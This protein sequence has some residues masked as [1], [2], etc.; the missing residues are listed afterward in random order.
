MT[1]YWRCLSLSL[2]TGYTQVLGWPLLVAALV[3]AS[4]GT[5]NGTYSDQASRDR[6]A[7]AYELLSGSAALQGRGYDLHTLGGIL[8]NEMGYLTLI[9]IPLIGVHLAIRFTRSV[10]DTGRL[11]ILTS[12]PV[13]RLAPAAAGV[14]A[15]AVTA[16]I[17]AVITAVG[18][19]ALDY[20]LGGSWLYAGGL[21]MFMLV[22]TGVGTLIAQCCRTARTAYL[23]AAGAWLIS[24]LARAAVD[25]QQWAAT[26]WNP[27]SWL[28]EIKP[29]AANPPWWP[30]I[31]SG[32]LAVGLFAATAAVA[33]R[34]DQGAGIIAPRPGPATAPAWVRSPFTLLARL[35]G[36]LGAGWAGASM[37]FAFAFGY[38]APQI[39]HL[40]AATNA[41]QGA[42]VNA[43]LTIFVQ[44][45]AL[46]A[47]AAGIQ[48][49]QWLAAEET[50]GRV[51]YSLST[52]VSRWRWWTSTTLLAT[53]WSMLVLLCGGLATGLGLEAGFDEGH[54]FGKGLTATLSYAAAVVLLTGVA[55]VVHSLSPR[56]VPV[57]WLPVGWGLVVCLRAD[58]LELPS[59]SRQLSPVHWIG[60]VP[61]DALHRPAALTMAVAA[62]VLV[63]VSTVRY[64]WRDLEAG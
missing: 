9:M 23:L 2:R 41:E 14:T 12:Y 26:G 17:T 31:A 63:V 55:V 39:N 20:P 5:I 62:V 34:R 46:L 11:D 32:L 59:W 28:A 37:L 24:Y 64:R 47:A 21:A 42:T 7:G 33:L 30:W 49:V 4:A 10:E 44:L 19:T 57:A 16:A 6:Y 43:T 29:F 56:A 40:D 18:L 50:A 35:T 38:L 54:Y 48:I 25:A 52:P 13:H 60:A 61:R 36:G 8:V 53:T 22:F 45:N 3:L 58:L 27:Q 1:G 15:A 51:G